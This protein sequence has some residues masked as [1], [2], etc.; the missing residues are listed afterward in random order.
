MLEPMPEK[1]IISMGEL[2]LT[3]IFLMSPAAKNMTGQM[4][5]LDRDWTAR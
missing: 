3:A 1:A 2:A 4:I 5:V